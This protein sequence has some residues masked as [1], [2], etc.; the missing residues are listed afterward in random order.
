MNLNGGT[1]LLNAGYTQ[2]G[3]DAQLNLY[4]GT[5]EGLEGTAV[6]IEE[7]RFAAT[8]T[9]NVDL[10]IGIDDLAKP[11]TAVLEVGGFHTIGQVALNGNTTIEST[12]GFGISLAAAP[13]GG[14][15]IAYDYANATKTVT[16]NSGTLILRV[17]NGFEPQAGQRFP[18]ITAT[19]FGGAGF[20]NLSGGF[21]GAMQVGSY[22]F[23]ISQEAG[24][25]AATVTSVPEPARVA[26]F[27]ALLTLGGAVGR[28]VCRPRAEGERT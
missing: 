25:L 13:E 28:R 17:L 8:G 5:L 4:D 11:I 23:E 19:A 14:A 22:G 27:V 6:T 1:L 10:F 18:I 7:G 2:T 12:G 21:S 9:L 20:I 15:G 16:V 24:E 3:P 26:T